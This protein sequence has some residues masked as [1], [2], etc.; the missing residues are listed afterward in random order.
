VN[1]LPNKGQFTVT[2]PMGLLVRHYAGE[3]VAQL[4]KD[5]ANLILDLEAKSRADMKPTATQGGFHTSPTFVNRKD[6]VV[7]KFREKILIPGIQHYMA[8]YYN[9]MGVPSTQLTPDK[10]SIQGWANITRASEWNAPHNHITPNF[11]LSA[12]YYLQ[13][14]DC[15]P[16]EGALQLDNPNQISCQHGTYGHAKFYPHAGDLVIF[17]C[18]QMHFSHPFTAPGERILIANDIRVHDRFDEIRPNNYN[19]MLVDSKTLR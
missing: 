5:L 15:H 19:C 16:P 12:V 2:F 18:Y 9:L 10:L 11:R 14:P 6:A 1:E 8:N 7:T 17:P 4:N 13:I 3:K